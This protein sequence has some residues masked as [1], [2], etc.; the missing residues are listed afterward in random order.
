MHL[1]SF[2][3]VSA[4]FSAWSVH[5]SLLIQTRLLFHWKKQYYVLWTCISAG[6]DCLKLKCLDGF[7]SFKQ[8]FFIS[9]DINWWTGVDYCDVFIS[10][11]DSFWRHPFTAEHP[12]LSKRYNATFFQIISD[13]ETNSSQ[14]ALGWIHFKQ[15]IF[16]K[17]NC[18]FNI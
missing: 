4:C 12:L 3:T 10:C 2:R 16:F 8:Q 9:Q 1:Y 13:K 17:V 15:I 5:S 14:V 11:L 6:S 7:V 18:S